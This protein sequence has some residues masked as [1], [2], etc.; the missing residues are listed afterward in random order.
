MCVCVCVCVRCP[1]V[2]E[3]NSKLPFSL[4]T[5]PSYK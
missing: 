5:T 1:T 2:V 3:D 4:T